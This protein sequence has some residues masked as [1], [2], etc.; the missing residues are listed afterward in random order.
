MSVQPLAPGEAAA[1]EHRDG[2]LAQ[3]PAASAG[4][5]CWYSRPIISSTTSS[6]V[7]CA[8]W[9]AGDVAAVAEHRALVGQLGD[10]VHAMRDVE[11]RQALLREPLEDGEHLGDVAGGERRGRL[12]K[13]ED[14]RLPHQRLGDL[15]HL[16]ARQR[17][18]LDAGARMD[19]L[20]PGTR[21]RRLGEPTLRGAVDQ[22]E[23][24]RR[25]R[26]GDIVG[27]RK[28]GHQR[29]LLEHAGDAG[30]GRRRRRGEARLRPVN[31]AC[32]PNRAATTPAM[33]LIS[34]DLPAPFSPRMAW[35]RPPWTVS[36]AFSRALTPP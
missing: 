7:L 14:A 12:V 19:L 34:V 35:M 30:S 17:Q 28:V 16:A 23:A 13:D 5:T 33:I 4:N 3:P 24:L 21:Q 26:D 36:S 22:P 27:H 6:S 10:L 20:G 18:V 2:G 1:L 11:Q 8:A 15:D 29:Q 32:G 9:I 25:P 31:A